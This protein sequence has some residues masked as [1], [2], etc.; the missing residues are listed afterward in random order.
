MRYILISQFLDKGLNMVA[1][2][3]SMRIKFNAEGGHSETVAVLSMSDNERFYADPEKPSTVILCQTA[4]PVLKQGRAGMETDTYSVVIQ[5]PQD[6]IW[7][8]FKKSANCLE[9]ETD[10][11]PERPGM[12]S[13]NAVNMP[14]RASKFS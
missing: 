10:D 5:K 3:G 7:D 11:K 9:V 13:T 1:S 8:A 6:E 12:L 14:L 4:N 2:I